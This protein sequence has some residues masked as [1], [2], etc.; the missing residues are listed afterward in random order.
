MLYKCK[1]CT[2]WTK[3]DNISY[4]PLTINYILIHTKKCLSTRLVCGQ[5]CKTFYWLMINTGEPRPLWAVWS[6]RHLVRGGLRN[7]AKYAH[8]DKRVSSIF[9]W[10]LLKFLPPGSCLSACLSLPPW[11]TVTWMYFL[12]HLLLVIEFFHKDNKQ[13]RTI[14]LSF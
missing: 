7:V 12:P 9:P 10:L 14:L 2:L 6:S 4:V 5:V 11:W 3:F 1:G 8:G 13:T